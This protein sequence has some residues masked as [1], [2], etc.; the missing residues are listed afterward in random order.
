MR[1]C[2]A[3][4]RPQADARR[5]DALWPTER[6]DDE[7]SLRD[8]RRSLSSGTTASEIVEGAVEALK[9]VCAAARCG[10]R[11]RL[12]RCACI[13]QLAQRPLEEWT[14]AEV[15]NFV[16]WKCIE[17]NGST[18]A[19]QAVQRLRALAARGNEVDGRWLASA[20]PEDFRRLVPSNHDLAD[21]LRFAR[22]R[23]KAYPD[24]SGKTTQDIDRSRLILHTFW[25]GL[26]KPTREFLARLARMARTTKPKTA[27]PASL[28]NPCILL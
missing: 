20:S 19:E 14:A 25:A 2:P 15:H 8:A 21:D 7:L 13:W 6:K 18:T 23:L 22:D 11:D 1:A 16:Q 4:T 5:V 24:V 17:K 26:T 10:A 27:T 28:M 3:H 12:L 9:Q